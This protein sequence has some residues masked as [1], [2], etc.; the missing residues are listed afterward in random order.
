[1]KVKKIAALAVGAAM[2]GATLGFASATEVPNIPKDFFVKNGEPNV[3]IVIGSQAAAQDVASAADIAVA[4]GTLLYTEEDVKVKDASV[5]V[6]K[7]V[8][9]DPADIPVFDNLYKGNYKLKEDLKDVEGWWNGAFDKDDYPEFTVTLKDSPWD[10]GI[11]NKD[12]PGWEDV[13]KVTVYN[14]VEWKD[15]NDNNYW[16]DPKGNWHD[17]TDVSIHYTVAIGKIELKGF[18]EV[19]TTDIDEF[20]DF[21]LIVDDVVA[22]V[23]FSLNAYEKTLKDKVLGATEETY[24]VSDVKPSSSYSLYQADVIKG[25]EKGDTITLF[26]KTIKVLDIGDDYI[27][28]GNDWGEKYVNKDE[29][30]TFGDYT[31]KVIDIDVNKVKALFEVS[32]PAGSKIVTLDTDDR[33][34]IKDSETLFNGGIRIKLLDTFIGI[35]GTTSA[36]IEVQT[37]ISY[38][39]DGKEFMPGWIAKLGIKDG[40]LEWFALQNKE[41]LEGKEVKLFDTYKVD[42]VADIMKKKNPKDDKTYAAMSAYVV[43]DPLKPEYTTKELGVGDELEGWTIDDIKAT[44]SPAKAAVV[45]KITTPITVLDDEII[46]AG[47]DSV[48]SNLILVGGPVV[49]K[50][51]AAL[52]D[53]LGVPTTY[54][55]WAADENLKAGVVKYI[56]NCPTIGGHGVVLVAG[57]DRDGT[58]AA[59]EALMEYLAG[60][61]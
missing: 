54:E 33:T 37:D 12:D 29:V 57:A 50:V 22:N 23:S 16:K 5:V 30:A 35:G 55:E 14:A 11:F 59:A 3:K 4:L 13:G 25:V 19:D 49:N 8:A 53:K 36:L 27:E 31:I 56:D 6:K 20:S 39:E 42:Y 48:D 18:D 51:T 40:K 10:D 32:G 17:A 1:M 43:I 46:E 41:E 60:L 2:V 44:A 28:Y 45:S 34:D 52:A 21:T 26:G 9:Y 24:A 58:K 15:G 61:H 47:L 38:I 7:D